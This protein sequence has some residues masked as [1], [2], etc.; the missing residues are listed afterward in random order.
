ML[1]RFATAV[2]DLSGGRLTLGLGA[3]WQDREH[4]NYG[5]DLLSLS[6]R[7]DRFE[8]GLEIITRLLKNDTPSD[9]IGNYYRLKEGILLPRPQRPSGPPILIGGNGRTRTLP[10]VARFADEWNGY[11]TSLDV[12]AK[13]NQ[14]LDQLADQAGRD[15][16]KIKRSFMMGCEYGRDDSEVKTLVT[17][18]TQ[19]RRTRQEL[20][21]T[22]GMAIGTASEIVDHLGQFAEAGLQRVMLQWLAQDDTDRLEHL[23]QHVLPQLQ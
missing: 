5:W 14:L 8:E 12:Y 21:D 16:A 7:F 23:A 18:R 11:Y 13:N 10:L 20:V 3:G 22:Y 2:D 9:Y 1:A 4:N 15:P 19:G 17:K 6:N